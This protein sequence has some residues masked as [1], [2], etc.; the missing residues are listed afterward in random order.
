MTV[1]RALI[2]WLYGFGNIDVSERIDTEA[3]AADAQ[4]LGLYKS[5]QTVVRAY[6][7]GSRNVTAHY[8]FLVKQGA[9]TNAERVESHAW[10]EALERWVREQD[11]ARLLPV[12]DEGR[13][14]SR[15]FVA[16]SFYMASHEGEEAVYQLSLGIQYMERVG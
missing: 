15:V 10:M 14:C 12:L 6:V 5:P 7:D 2:E 3:L 13:E 16:S 4:S 8:Q 9:Q 1:S 11:M